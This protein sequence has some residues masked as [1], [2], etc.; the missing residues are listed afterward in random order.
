MAVLTDLTEPAHRFRQAA[1]LRCCADVAQTHDEIECVNKTAIDLPRLLNPVLFTIARPY[2]VNPALQM[3]VL[4]GLAQVA[5]LAALDPVSSE[6]R[7]PR[8]WLVRQ[9]NRIADTLRRT[10]IWHRSSRNGCLGEP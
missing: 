2:D 1:A 9:R 6:Y 3:P 4:P 5:E 7:F 10:F 8:T